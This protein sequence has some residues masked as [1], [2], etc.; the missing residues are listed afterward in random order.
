MI[1]SDVDLDKKLI[2]HKDLKVF[3]RM[4]EGKAWIRGSFYPSD[5]KKCDLNSFVWQIEGKNET[6]IGR[7]NI[8]F[9]RCV[10]SFA[11]GRESFVKA[12]IP[13]GTNYVINRNLD[14]L[15]SENLY[16]TDEI[17]KTKEKLLTYEEKYDLIKPLLDEISNNGVSSGWLLKS[18]KTLIS[19]LQYDKSIE[20]DI[21]GIVGLVK[22]GIAYVMA[23]QDKLRCF[24]VTQSYCN[25][26]LNDKDNDY[27]G[28]LYT[29]KAKDKLDK[30]Y[31]F[32]YCL[33]YQTKGTQQGD[34][35]LPS[36][37][38]LHE[39]ILGNITKFNLIKWWTHLNF[40]TFSEKYFM[41][42]YEDT[43]YSYIVVSEEG[44]D[45]YNK[46]ESSFVR[47]FLRLKF[48]IKYICQ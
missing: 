29:E 2:A 7:R 26:M 43:N 9:D 46:I 1:I 4:E 19:P 39:S 15:Y 12:I 38:E 45:F 28:K 17:Y 20:E 47:P 5:N 37:G 14:K 23:L 27:N 34:W 31:G 16:I 18:D 21:I 36:F 41:S 22:D 40:S 10:R 6:K 42:S 11:Y 44:N 8:K 30:H 3:V 32:K 24:S 33:E 48:K 13:K 35:Y 25:K